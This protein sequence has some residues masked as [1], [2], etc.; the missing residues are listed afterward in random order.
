MGID[1]AMERG[2]AGAVSTYVERLTRAC[3]NDELEGVDAYQVTP[4][5]GLLP[6]DAAVADGAELFAAYLDD[7]FGRGSPGSV[8]AGLLTV[9]SQRT[10]AGRFSFDNEPDL[11]D[12]LRQNL[13]LRG[14]HARHRAP[15]F[16]DRSRVRGDA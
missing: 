4:E 6:G 10:P 9:A 13:R 11:F 7:A 5:R 8:I 16:R 2:A 14:Q 3:P 12:P 15:R 1:A